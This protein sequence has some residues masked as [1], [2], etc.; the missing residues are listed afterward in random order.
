MRGL[1]GTPWRVVGGERGGSG[2]R[3]SGLAPQCGHCVRSIPVTS[4]IHCTTFFGLRGG[5]LE[6]CPGSARQRGRGCALCRLARKP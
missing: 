6:G 1:Q 4:C 5:S 2:N 3:T